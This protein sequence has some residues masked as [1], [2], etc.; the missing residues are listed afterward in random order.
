MS[1]LLRPTF[2]KEPGLTLDSR[3]CEATNP[4]LDGLTLDSRRCE[5]TNP[6]LDGLTKFPTDQASDTDPCHCNGSERCLSQ[7]TT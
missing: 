7:P 2:R 1:G 5:A 3:R 4:R 6:R